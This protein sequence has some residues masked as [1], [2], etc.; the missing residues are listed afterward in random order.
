MCPSRPFK[1]DIRE[2]AAAKKSIM[3]TYRSASFRPRRPCTPRA[4]STTPRRPAGAILAVPSEC[5]V[6]ATFSRSQS[7]IAASSSAEYLM[8]SSTSRPPAPSTT[9]STHAAAESGANRGWPDETSPQYILVRRMI[10]RCFLY[11][12]TCFFRSMSSLSE[13]KPA[14]KSI[15]SVMLG[16]VMWTWPREYGYLRDGGHVSEPRLGVISKSQYSL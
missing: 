16:P 1:R 12:H 4:S 3:D 7:S 11:A 10:S 13:R 14:S 5:H 6:V 15:G 2:R 9:S 8:S